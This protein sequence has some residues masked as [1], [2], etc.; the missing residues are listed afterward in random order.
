MTEYTAP[1]GEAW[2]V[3]VLT[4]EDDNIFSASGEV[5]NVSCTHACFNH[6]SFLLVLTVE[7]DEREANLCVCIERMPCTHIARQREG[8]ANDGTMT[9]TVKTAC[10]I[11]TLGLYWPT[12]STSWQHQH[13]WERESTCVTDLAATHERAN[14]AVTGEWQ[15]CRHATCLCAQALFACA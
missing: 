1:P 15:R 11:T 13:W 7:D 9:K 2:N 4:V 8:M 12:A 6:E 5:W 10:A 14:I 3:Y